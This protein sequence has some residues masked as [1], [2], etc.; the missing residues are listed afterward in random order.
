MP[1]GSQIPG[2]GVQE[3]KFS[4][5]SEDGFPIGIKVDGVLDIEVGG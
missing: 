5:C 2:I 4:S 1:V 3:R